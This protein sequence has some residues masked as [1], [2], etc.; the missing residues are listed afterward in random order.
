MISGAWP[1]SRFFGLKV[2]K[3]G[4]LNY[5]EKV[6]EA[7]GEQVETVG[8]DVRVAVIPSEDAEAG[9]TLTLTGPTEA[10]LS[11]ET[12][13]HAIVAVGDSDGILAKL[14]GIAVGVDVVAS[15]GTP[16]TPGSG[17]FGLPGEFS[18][19]S[20]SSTPVLS[21]DAER[22]VSNPT[23]FAI[24]EEAVLFIGT[25]SLLI[26]ESVSVADPFIDSSAAGGS[27]ILSGY[28]STDKVVRTSVT[29]SGGGETVVLWFPVWI[30][31]E[32]A[33]LFNGADAP[34]FWVRYKATGSGTVT[35]AF[36]DSAVA[37]HAGSP[38]AAA[39]NYTTTSLLYASLSTSVITRLTLC[40]LKV[41][42]AG[43]AGDVIQVESMLGFRYQQRKEYT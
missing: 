21:G 11:D 14:V 10:D 24:D 39:S 20:D 16:I 40:W 23:G 7:L 30:P 15:P 43:G 3:P 38:A 37:A 28:S 25:G 41:T 12:P 34:T 27:T 2:P 42:I 35:L 31:A 29:I 4:V 32:Y 18:P 6:Q 17:G 19:I 9:R 1:T 36:V 13:V 22:S 26:H 8:K 33:S 5:I